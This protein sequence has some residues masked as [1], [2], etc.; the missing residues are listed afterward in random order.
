MDTFLI[1]AYGF[2]VIFGAQTLEAIIGTV[3]QSWEGKYFQQ[4]TA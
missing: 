3:L 2:I 4:A 1:N